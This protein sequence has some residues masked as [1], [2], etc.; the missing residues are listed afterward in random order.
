MIENNRLRLSGEIMGNIGTCKSCGILF[1]KNNHN[2]KYCSDECRKKIRAKQSRAKSNRHY[3][4]SL[5]G[6][7][8]EHHCKKIA[9][10]DYL[11]YNYD[12][13][14]F[15]NY[16]HHTRDAVC[17]KVACLKKN[18]WDKGC[19][20]SSVKS[21]AVKGVKKEYKYYTI[22]KGKYCVRKT[23]NGKQKYYGRFDNED[24]AIKFVESLKK[25]DWDKN[26]LN[27]GD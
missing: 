3:Y 25:V 26:K 6:L 20:G 23:I 21:S 15:I 17:D 27:G 14:Q 19:V 18:D 7:D 5:Y 10:D 1:I 24:D 22:N 13:E 11:I 9:D 16:K 4:T 12:G 8:K 2:E